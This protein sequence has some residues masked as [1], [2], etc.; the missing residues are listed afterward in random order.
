VPSRS[1]TAAISVALTGICVCVAPAS[2]ETITLICEANPAFNAPAMTLVYEGDAKG[3]LTIT[4]PFGNI[5]FAATKEVRQGSDEKGKPISAA[6][7]LGGG[8]ATVRMPEK[9][10]IESCVKKKLQ[11][12]QLA[13]SDLVFMAVMDCANRAPLG[14]EP[15]RID[16][17]VEIAIEP[18]VYVGLT[19][20]YLEPT[21]LAGRTIKLEAYPNCSRKE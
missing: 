1:V 8:P 3:T 19:R 13:D 21:Q 10:A 14:A 16:A 6:G 12:D 2:A 17:S 9:A 15:I 4:A 18:L 20:T 11:P 7:I 5:S